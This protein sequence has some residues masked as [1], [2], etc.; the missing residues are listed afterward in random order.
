MTLLCSI[1]LEMEV[2]VDDRQLATQLKQWLST[3][4]GVDVNEFVI[5]KHYANDDKD[6]Y[7]N[8]IK[9]TETVHDAY[10]AVQRVRLNCEKSQRIGISQEWM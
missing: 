3:V 7:E 1:C 9:E 10:Y 2:D 4:I 5:L 6:G 8:I